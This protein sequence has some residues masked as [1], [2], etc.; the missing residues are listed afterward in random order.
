[1]PRPLPVTIVAWVIIALSIEAVIPMAFGL[2]PKLIETFM[3]TS[4]SISATLWSAIAVIIANIIFAALMLRGFGWARV[5]YIALLGLGIFGML[6]HHYS[7]P[8]TA[9][10]I[11][12][13][14]IFAFFL[15]RKDANAYFSKAKAA[16]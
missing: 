13:I 10:A 6:W 1:M 4:L 5:A 16:A 3:T 9:A 11:L 14:A 12:K 2:G 15:F 7:S 8:L